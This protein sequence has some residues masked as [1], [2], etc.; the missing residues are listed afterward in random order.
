M[1]C[2]GEVLNRRVL[3]HKREAWHEAPGTWHLPAT[4]LGLAYTMT[5]AMG[6]GSS[7]VS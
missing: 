2:E 3:E 1:V 5:Y 7:D 4:L 6:L